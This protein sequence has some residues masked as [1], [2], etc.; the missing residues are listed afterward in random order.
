M[1]VKDKTGQIWATR[2]VRTLYFPSMHDFTF[3]NIGF[4]A[5]PEMRRHAEQAWYAR[6]RGKGKECGGEGKRL[7]HDDTWHVP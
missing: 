7:G 6:V 3:V 1:H 2:G 4:K 5:K